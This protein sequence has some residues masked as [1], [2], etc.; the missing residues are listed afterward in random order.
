MFF[1]D[2]DHGWM[3]G[4]AGQVIYSDDGARSWQKQETETIAPLY[5]IARLA[6][7]MYVVGGEGVL[8]KQLGDKWK[9]LQLARPT[10]MY[11]RVILPIADDRLLVA[12]QQGI[13]EVMSADNLVQQ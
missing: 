7:E 13:L 6:N 5:N 4:L 2:E 1:L 12:G 8:L 10:Q 9:S 11:L 3:V